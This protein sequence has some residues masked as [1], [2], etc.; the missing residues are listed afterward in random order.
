VRPGPGGGAKLRIIHDL[1]DAR[2]TQRP[3]PA[4]SN[5]PPLMRAA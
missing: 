3:S 5:R 4:N 1:T 2:L